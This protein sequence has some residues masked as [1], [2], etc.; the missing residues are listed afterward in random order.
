M[1]AT[2]KPPNGTSTQRRR[3]RFSSLEALGFTD[4]SSSWSDAPHSPTS[5]QRGRHL[6]PAQPETIADWQ[7]QDFGQRLEGSNVRWSAVV[8]VVLLLGGIAG[9]G[10]WMYQR[11]AAIELAAGAEVHTQARALDSALPFLSEFNN[12]LLTMDTEIGA[13]G[14]DPVENAARALFDTSGRL[15]QADLR[16]MASQAAGSSLD[17]IRLARQTHAY[18]S[19]VM[20]LLDTPQFETDRELIE[21]DE[22]ARLFGNWQREFDGMRTALPDDVLPRVTEQIDAISAE[23]ASFLRRYVDTLRSG[24]PSATQNVLTALGSRLDV[25]EAVLDDSTEDLQARIEIRLDD[26]RIAL[27]RILSN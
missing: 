6:A 11:P 3:V 9:F 4:V 19:A 8:V 23:L 24:D 20:P 14:L 26:T 15:T 1:T 12:E 2:T 13:E 27:D 17:G 25:I 18:R 22:A 16:S 5:D 7:P 21:L 10:Y